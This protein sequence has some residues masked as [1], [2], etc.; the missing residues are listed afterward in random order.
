M[1]HAVI[2][3]IA[4]A[5]SALVPVAV[6]PASAQYYGSATFQFGHPFGGPGEDVTVFPGE[7]CP[8]GVVSATFEVWSPWR[9]I[10]ERDLVLDDAGWWEPFTGNLFPVTNSGG[11]PYRTPLVRCV[12]AE[13]DPVDQYRAVDVDEHGHWFEKG[14]GLEDPDVRYVYNVYADLFGREVDPEGMDTW[15]TALESGTP[16]IAVSNAITYSTEFRSGLIRGA[17][18]Y[19]LGRAPDVHGLDFW[20]Q[21][22]AAGLTYEQLEAGFVASAEFYREAGST[23]DAW[24]RTVYEAVLGR[25]A[26]DSEVR[27]WV[28]R[29]PR[30]GYGQVALGFL[31]ST[32][33]LTH[34]VDGYYQW[35]LSRSVDPVGRTNWVHA[36]QTGTRDEAIIGGILASEEYYGRW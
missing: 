25:P 17:Y 35:L 16:R 32:E 3:V 18:D 26:G 13:G 4:A 22:M 8:A 14:M 28:A 31:M 29:I 24:V 1:R 20:L 2:A 6:Q 11:T 27:D 10:F 36:I 12:M 5:A 33:H 23:D 19:Y 15:V 21:Q 9:P 30:M 7:P 34:V